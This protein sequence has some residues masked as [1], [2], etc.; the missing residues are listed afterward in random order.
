MTVRVGTASEYGVD[1][2]PRRRSSAV[3]GGGVRGGTSAV[4]S[5]GAGTTVI[6]SFVWN[7]RIQGAPESLGVFPSD[8]S[9]HVH[10]HP[11]HAIR[12][13]PL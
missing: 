11:V 2:R 1:H 8:L 9:T 6:A 12:T 10:T 5:G 3:R 4:A 7:A 13:I